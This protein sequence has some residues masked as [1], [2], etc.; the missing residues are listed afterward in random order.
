MKARFEPDELQALRRSTFLP[1][2]VSESLQLDRDGR[3]FVGLCPFHQ[4]KT[5]SLTVYQDHF[6]CFGCGKH[7]DVFDWFGLKCGLTLPE[8]VQLLA[9]RAPADDKSILRSRSSERRKAAPMNIFGIWNEAKSPYGS[10]VETYLRNRGGLAIPNGGAIRVHPRAQRGPR[11]IAGGPE[12]WPAMLA[13]MTDPLSA[14]AVGVHRTFLLPNGAG[15]A[16]QTVRGRITLK[17]KMV[18]GSWGCVR[19]AVDDD[20]GRA[21]AIA[22][23]IENALAASQILGWG[24]VWAAGTQ[25]QIARFPV[26][27]GIEALTIFADADD[28]GVGLLAAQACATRWRA[29]GREAVIHV[30]PAGEDWAEAA[31]RLPR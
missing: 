20:I 6:H 18:L 10:V 31:E 22:E 24:P 15:K 13:L 23:G 17:P 16:P 29:A 5:A 3:K 19:L 12:F 26:L 30:P 4:E 21:I 27:P 9:S 7:G 25:G 11:D 2:I 1:R 14:R 28:Q 8:V